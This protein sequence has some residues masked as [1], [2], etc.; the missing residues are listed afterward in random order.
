MLE[1][2]T[3][4]YRDSVGGLIRSHR[5]AEWPFAFLARVGFYGRSSP[6]IRFSAAPG[7]A[8]P[9]AEKQKPREWLGAF[10]P[11]TRA[12]RDVATLVTGC[13]EMSRRIRH[14]I[15]RAHLEQ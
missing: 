8:I 14:G 1:L 9:T 2:A 5:R 7:C 3:G 13:A 12:R 11:I 15:R 10:A 6:G 4:E